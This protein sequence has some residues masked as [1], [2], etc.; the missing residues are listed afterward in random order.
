M[1]NRAFALLT[2]VFVLGVIAAMVV[3]SQW[4]GGDTTAR[5]PYRVVSTHPV[6][7]LNEQGTVR[8]RGISVGRVTRIQLDPKDKR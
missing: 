6:S 4:L 3:W 1:E 5:V 8:Y 2:G 7:G